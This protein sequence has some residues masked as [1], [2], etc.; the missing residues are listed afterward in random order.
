MIQAIRKAKYST[1]QKRQSRKR[2]SSRKSKS[3]LPQRGGDAGRFVLPPE[4]FG[5]NSGA[6]YADGSDALNSCGQRAVSQGVLHSS[7]LWAGPNLKPM[8][9]G[10]CGCSG[11]KYRSKNRNKRNKN[12]RRQTRTRK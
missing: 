11:R 8:M 5:K 3:G 6:Y 12:G 2:S 4:Y 10:S 7:G 9:G 1:K